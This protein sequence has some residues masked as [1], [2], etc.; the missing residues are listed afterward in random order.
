MLRQKL[1][2]LYILLSPMMQALLLLYMPLGI[3]LAVTQKLPVWVTL[4]SFIP[5]YLF[6]LQL[7]TTLI[8]LYIFTKEYKLR[9]SLLTPLRVLLAFYPYQLMLVFSAFRAF[10]R[11]L[12]S[13]NVWEKTVHTNAH[14]EMADL[15]LATQYVE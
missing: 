4:L 2:V 3:A 1:V 11:M 13:K 10:Y 5:L 7:L 15:Q 9:F 6:A 12:T 14:R 8:G